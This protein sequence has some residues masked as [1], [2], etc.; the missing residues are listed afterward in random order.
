[1]AR[2]EGVCECGAGSWSM[3]LG[4]AWWVLRAGDSGSWCWTECKE[5]GRVRY[6][7]YAFD[8]CALVIALL[9]LG[10]VVWIKLV[11]VMCLG[12]LGI[13]SEVDAL[14]TVGMIGLWG[15]Q[16]LD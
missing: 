16:R 14:S 3:W 11:G 15:K 5:G 8:M 13:R 1:M 6:Y 9:G 10:L 2:G 12:L 7:P 4:V